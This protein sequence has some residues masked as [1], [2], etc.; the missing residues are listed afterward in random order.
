MNPQVSV[1]SN[2]RVA[3]AIVLD[4][5]QA[6]FPTGAGPGTF[7]LKDDTLFVRTMVNGL[8]SWF[9]LI[10]AA[11]ATWLHTQGAPMDVWTVTHNLNSSDVWYQVQDIDGNIIG[12]SSFEKIDDDSFKLHFSEPITGTVLVV[13]ANNI[14]VPE[15]QT[16][17]LNVGSVVRIDNSGIYINDVAVA[18]SANALKIGNSVSQQMTVQPGER[19]DFAAGT[20]VA[21][22]FDDAT[23]KITIATS[24]D[25][26]IIKTALG[27]TPINVNKIDAAS[28]I[29]SLDANKLLPAAYLSSALLTSV[30]GF[31]P[32]DVTKVG[33]ANG[34]AP[35]GSDGLISSTY[36]P[37]Y[38]DDV[39][40]VDTKAELPATGAKGKIYLVDADESDGGKTNQYRWSGSTYLKITSSPGSTDAVAEGVTNLYY[41]DARTRA[42]VLTGLSLATSTAVT[43]TDSILSAVGKLQAQ[44]TANKL[45]NTDGLTE[46][47]ANLYFTQA[48]VRATPLTG[49]VTST[50]SAV[51][52]G[53]TVLTAIGKLQ[54]QVTAG[55]T[56]SSFTGVPYDMAGACSGKP[57]SSAI[58]APLIVARACNIPAGM[59]NSVAR[60][61]TAP[62][63]N[64]VFNIKKN[65][66]TVGTLTFLAGQNAGTFAAA[67]AISLAAGDLLDV[68]APGTQDST[69][70]D[71]RLTIAATLA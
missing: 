38:V 63:A 43:A 53:D 9:P 64:A 37:S 30:L 51:T 39:I 56:I 24:L 42:A 5:D 50:N 69:L 44:V 58:I 15:I 34:V 11:S 67:S 62:T 55:S 23:N 19:L 54:A 3:G 41:T 71:V 61:T 66:T 7:V 16:N 48:R 59:T 2:L 10:R 6:D 14:D 20:G 28:G 8:M 22:A 12:I 45:T 26:S 57:S 46:G 68:V 35:L 17:V 49:L 4:K 31:T 47:A 40:E 70:S 33:A 13:A 29:A 21:L 1:L 65:G 18:T 27:Y 32:L 36:L 25:A 52:S 60:A